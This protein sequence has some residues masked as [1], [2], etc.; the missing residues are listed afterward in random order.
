M[1]GFVLRGPRGVWCA[2]R[3]SLQGLRAAW[4]TEPSFR[5]EA[6][7]FVVC[8]PLALWL[9]EGRV[10]KAVLA[11][12]LLPIPAAEL[13]NSGIEAL[14]DKLWPERDPVAGHIK[15]W[16]GAAVFL[17]IVNAAVVWALVLIRW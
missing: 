13:F 14:V 2:L 5:L 1:H 7:L 11:G 9:G 3:W 8:L 16:G 15:D 4:R 17:L 6:V 12:V 10:E